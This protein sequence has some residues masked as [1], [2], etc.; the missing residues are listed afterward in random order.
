PDGSGSPQ[1]G[2]N[3]RSEDYK[4]TAGI[5]RPN[6][7]KQQKGRRFNYW[8]QAFHVEISAYLK[9]GIAF[10]MVRV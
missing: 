5:A 6:S 9:R 4:H 1:Q 2:R 7:T 3:D 10:E 8:L